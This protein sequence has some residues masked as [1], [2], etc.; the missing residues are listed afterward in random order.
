M[1]VLPQIAM[2]RF[3]AGRR[4]LGQLALVLPDQSP[5][6]ASIAWMKSP[7]FGMYIMPL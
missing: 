6:R 4:A 7:G 2:L 5:V 1:I 3:V